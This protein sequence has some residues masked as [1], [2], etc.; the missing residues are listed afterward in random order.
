MILRSNK[1]NIFCDKNMGGGCGCSTLTSN[2]SHYFFLIKEKNKFSSINLSLCPVRNTIHF[3]KFRYS[4]QQNSILKRNYPLCV[5]KKTLQL[6]SSWAFINIL[7]FLKVY[8]TEIMKI[9]FKDE[10]DFARI[11]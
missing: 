6:V 5:Y 2:G 3:K 8:H 4:Y 1:P 11:V 7:Y 9:L 10:N